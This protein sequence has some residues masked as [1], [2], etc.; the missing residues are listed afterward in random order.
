MR[1]L[2]GDDG[3]ARAADARAVGDQRPCVSEPFIRRR[4]IRHLEKGRAVV[5]PADRQS[6][7]HDRHLCAALRATEIEANVLLKATKVD[8]IYTADPKK[9]RRP[10]CTPTSLTTGAREAVAR[11][12]P[13]GDHAV[14]GAEDPAGRV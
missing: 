2:A 3:G 12:G 13:D 14:Q 10:R 4:A 8:G 6:V 11:D 9:D 5:L 7:F 1:W